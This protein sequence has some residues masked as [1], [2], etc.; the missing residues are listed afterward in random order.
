MVQATSKQLM[1]NN[2]T[3]KMTAL[4]V[5]TMSLNVTAEANTSN[6]ETGELSNQKEYRF[7]KNGGTGSSADSTNT[8]VTV[9]GD[10]NAFYGTT[11]KDIELVDGT[12]LPTHGTVQKKS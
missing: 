8:N 2:T 6:A 9:N 7:D 1:E 4:F 11:D 12:S 5:R 3:L 10:K